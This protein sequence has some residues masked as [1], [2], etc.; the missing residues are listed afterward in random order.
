MQ[1][2]PTLCSTETDTEQQAGTVNSSAT[3]WNS[4]LQTSNNC[5][6]LCKNTL[7]LNP[8]T[9]N[10]AVPLVVTLEFRAFLSSSIDDDNLWESLRNQTYVSLSQ[11]LTQDGT[12][13]PPLKGL[14]RSQIWVYNA[15][16]NASL[17]DTLKAQANVYIFPLSGH[18][19]MDSVT[20]EFIMR[21]FT[22]QKVRYS[23]PFRPNMVVAV[24]S[25][26][27]KSTFSHALQSFGSFKV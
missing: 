8:Y 22:S 26:R 18:N 13:R 17:T 1:V 23:S 5:L 3:K 20:E 19:V 21:S 11:L 2:N 15:F 7:T 4:P 25:S 10:C 14:A 12:N 16:F 24:Q 27:G 9:C 6:I